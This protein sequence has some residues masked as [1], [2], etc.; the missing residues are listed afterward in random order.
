LKGFI[1]AA[2]LQKLIARYKQYHL[3]ATVIRL[4]NKE[5]YMKRFSVFVMFQFLLVSFIFAQNETVV[6]GFRIRPINNGQGI[7]I[8]GYEGSGKVVQIPARIRGLP[9]THIG[10]VAFHQKNLISVTIPNSVTSIGNWAF[11]DNKLTTVTI[12]NSVTLIEDGA[13][14][15]N[16]LTSIPSGTVLLTLGKMRLVTTN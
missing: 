4:S 10:Q 2:G 3:D 6:D 15:S 11:V 12:P 7:E 13:F 16:Q 9:V 1:T 8:T 5:L 14:S